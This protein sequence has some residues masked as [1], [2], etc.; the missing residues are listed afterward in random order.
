MGLKK[1]A[2]L[3]STGSIGI[4]TLKVIER[5]PDN[6]KVTS[7]S[8][9]NN[10]HLLEQQIK[11]FLPKRVA[12]QKNK[13]SDLRKKS[14]AKSVKIFEIETEIEAFVNQK[15]IDIVILAIQGGAAL[16]PFLEAV[17]CGK[18][19]APANKEALVMAGS[20]IMKE[21]K[22]YKAVIVPVDSEQS[23]IFQC[24]DNRNIK[25][26]KKVYLTASGGSLKDVKKSQ[27]D[28]LTVKKVLNHPRW[29]M[30]KKIT[31]DSATLMN[32]GL[33]VIEAMWLFDLKVDQIEILIHPE[34]IIHS[35]VEFIDG[36]IL[37][38]LGVTDMRIPIQY[39]LTYPSRD[40]TGLS[41]LN[42][43]KQK[44]LTFEK[45]DLRKF[46]SLSLCC[47]VARKGGT[48]GSV[49]NAANEEAVDAF[50]KEKI[51]FSQIYKIVERVVRKHKIIKNPDLDVILQADEWARQE[52]QKGIF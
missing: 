32:K 12:L 14:C 31:V 26:L 45:P 29:R 22:K 50:L 23:A 43:L 10:I 25:D 20:L 16:K 38:Q 48:L 42:F 6:F 2:I 13:I 21:A 5:F 4:N 44:T 30:G 8:A 1:V 47:Q 40:D 24:L 9:Y 28:S 7:L 36:S 49:L 34:S 39:A 35:M 19:V 37:A 52:A 17:R 15:D 51:K 33:E 18:I 11:K 41:P 3:G 27:F 46:P